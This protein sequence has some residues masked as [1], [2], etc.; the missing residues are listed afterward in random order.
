[1][2]STN[3][4]GFLLYLWRIMKN[5]DFTMKKILIFALAALMLTGVSLPSSAQETGNEKQSRKE[6]REQRRA[7][8]A[9]RDSLN[10][11][12]AESDSINVGYGYTKR[13]HLTTAVSK[14]SIKDNEVVNYS[15]IGEY[16]QGRVPGL[17]VYKRGSSYKYVIRGIN[18]INS[19]T[20]PLFI[21]DGSAVND[22]SYLSP[23]D[24]KSV[25]VLKDA[26]ASIYGSR[27][28]CGVIIITTK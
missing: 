22:I 21:V 8:R 1:M 4:V 16:L 15:D 25:E 28:A 3:L 14:V 17:S 9:I 2:V 12:K 27:G 20:D 24:V 10:L 7:L 18:S 23:K 26:S 13:K 19:S 5:N 6:R 11:L